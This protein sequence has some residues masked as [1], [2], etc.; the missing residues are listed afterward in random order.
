MD[1]PASGDGPSGIGC[2]VALGLVLVPAI[3]LSVFGPGL[4]GEEWPFAIFWG[5]IFAVPFGY[6][7]LATRKWRPW[8]FTAFLTIC[9]WGAL[10]FITARGA[11]GVGFGIVLLM[12]AAP[13]LITVG[14]WTMVDPISEQSPD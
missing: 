11:P 14:A 2:A 9:V 5:V 1:E 10:I 3:A 7:A 4:P 6:L 8:V 13:I 12:L